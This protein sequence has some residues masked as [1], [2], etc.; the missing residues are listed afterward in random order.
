MTSLAAEVAGHRLQFGA[1]RLLVDGV[2]QAM[3]DNSLLK[4]LGDDAIVAKRGGKYIVTAPGR[5]GQVVAYVD[6]RSVHFYVPEGLS[7]EGLLGNNDGE[8]NNDLFLNDGTQLPRT[9]SPAMLHGSYADSWRISPEESFFTYASQQGTATFT[10]KTFPSNVIKISDFADDE[11]EAA[12]AI[13]RQA[14]VEAG[15]GFED[16][17]YDVLITGDADYATPRPQC[18]G[19]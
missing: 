3:E 18:P 19:S 15:P 7:T 10:D 17:V 12:A 9:A 2:V 14:G 5:G 6:G 13:C 8:P 11:I 16:C 4:R 1:N